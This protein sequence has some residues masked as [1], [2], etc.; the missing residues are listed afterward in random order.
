MNNL[1]LVIIKATETGLKSGSYVSKSLVQS[2][3]FL[4]ESTIYLHETKTYVTVAVVISPVS[5][6]WLLWMYTK[7]S[8]GS[9]RN[10]SLPPVTWSWIKSPRF[11]ESAAKSSRPS[12][13]FVLNVMSILLI[14]LLNDIL[15]CSRKEFFPKAG[16]WRSLSAKEKK[17]IDII[18]YACLKQLG[19]YYWGESL[20]PLSPLSI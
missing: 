2:S 3:L 12:D 13:A 1:T 16:K 5:T 8:P 6:L 10:S 4:L 17:N 20:T 15:L 9:N 14:S 7:L 18:L 11:L 19:Y